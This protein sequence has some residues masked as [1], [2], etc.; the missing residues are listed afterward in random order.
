MRPPMSLSW[1]LAQ[2]RI[3][4]S[5]LVNALTGGK[6]TV[7]FSAQCEWQR[8][9]GATVASRKRGATWVRCLN[10]L[11]GDDRHCQNAYDIEAQRSGGWPRRGEFS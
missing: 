2:V 7:T 8:L 1:H 5:H 3:A 4:L 11:T 9:N 6:G 10:Y